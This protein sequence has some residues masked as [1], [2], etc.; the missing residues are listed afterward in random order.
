MV[1]IFTIRVTRVNLIIHITLKS[2][3][4]MPERSYRLTSDQ[5]GC[6]VGVLPF[7]RHSLL[8]FYISSSSLNSSL[9]IFIFSFTT[10]SLL[11]HIL[12]IIFILCSEKQSSHNYITLV[13]WLLQFNHSIS[14]FFVCCTMHDK[15][16][17]IFCLFAVTCYTSCVFFCMSVRPTFRLITTTYSKSITAKINDNMMML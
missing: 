3:N 8:S 10:C 5:I 12:Y 16:F 6:V 11:H 14:L 15:M 1:T 2:I 13:I 4:L 7:Q 9:S 17:Y